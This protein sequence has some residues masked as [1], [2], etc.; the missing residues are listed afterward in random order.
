M[1]G[2]LTLIQHKQKR[3]VSSSSDFQGITVY[4]FFFV[5]N[6]YTAFEDLEC[7]QVLVLL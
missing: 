3:F 4:F 5:Q 2:T 1:K 6:C 7:S